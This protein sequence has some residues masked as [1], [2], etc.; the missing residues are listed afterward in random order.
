MK[1]HFYPRSHLS[2]PLNGP[3]SLRIRQPRRPGSLP[4]LRRR[5]HP[6]SLLRIFRH[7]PPTHAA[8]CFAERKGLADQRRPSPAPRPATLAGG[9]PHGLR[10]PLVGSEVGDLRRDQI[11]HQKRT[12]GS[13][14]PHRRGA[15][16]EPKASAQDF[17]RVGLKPLP[18]YF[19]LVL[20]DK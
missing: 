18:P 8:A 12:V 3:P 1:L 11:G 4:P 14:Q 7:P 5:R 10:E 15:S 2:P 17:H 19:E 13:A 20:V 6:R 16:L 9:N